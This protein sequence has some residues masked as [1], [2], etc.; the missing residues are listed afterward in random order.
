MNN[1][2]KALQYDSS[3]EYTIKMYDQLPYIRN[4]N[5]CSADQIKLV[6]GNVYKYYTYSKE[7][8]HEISNHDD[9][10]EAH[11]RQ[12]EEDAKLLKEE[13][14]SEDTEE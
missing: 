12:L 5:L 1:L 4:V 13:P 7:E 14:I 2:Q 11:I 8:V 3:L 9:I 10:I 6:S